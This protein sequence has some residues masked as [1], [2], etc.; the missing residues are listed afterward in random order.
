MSKILT[1]DCLAVLETLPPES[2]HCCV[3]SPPYYGLRNYGVDGQIGLEDSPEAFV[4]RLIS[5]FS[6][7]KRVL[8]NDGTLWLNLGDSYAGSGKA[9]YNPDYQKKH[10]QFGQK[11][12]KERL[13]RPIP[14]KAIG[15]KPKDLVGIPWMVAFALRSDGWYLRS[16]IIWNK[17]NPMP[18]PVKDRPSTAHEYIFLLTKSVTY[19]Y[20]HENIKVG[21]ANKKSVWTVPTNGFGGAHYATY[22][23]DLIKPCILAGCPR[24]GI[25]LDPFFGAGTTCVAAKEMNRRY[26]GIEMDADYAKIARRRVAHIQNGLF[27]GEEN[28]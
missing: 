9:G 15:L 10:T 21:G 19:Y 3:T 12:R 7:V 25:V 1:G 13:G 11:E 8:R 17:P 23:E 22:P 16:D 24:E 20:D 5:V 14:A 18:N 27:N 2:V 26:I 6:E 28:G 4:Q